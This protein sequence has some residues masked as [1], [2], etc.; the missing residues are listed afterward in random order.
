[1]INKFIA[2]LV[3]FCV[4]FT[5][6]GFAEQKDDK[7]V[8]TNEVSVSS[9]PIVVTDTK[10]DQINNAISTLN[11]K[12]ELVQSRYVSLSNQVDELSKRKSNMQNENQSLNEPTSIADIQSELKLMRSEIAQ[13]REDASIVKVNLDDKQNGEDSGSDKKWYDSKW[14]APCAFAISV[15]AVFVAVIK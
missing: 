6:F 1:M 11:Y 8:N 2:Q 13:I 5:S 15:I 12:L 9:A 4:L 3:C 14:V 10:N 7:L